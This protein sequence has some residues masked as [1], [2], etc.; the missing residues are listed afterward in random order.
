M[1]SEKPPAK[2]RRPL[3]A[4]NIFFKFERARLLALAERGESLESHPPTVVPVSDIRELLRDNPY[5]VDHKKRRH[6]RSHGMVSFSALFQTVLGNWKELTAEMRAPFDEI[7]SE[8]KAAYDQE[9]VEYK[10]WKRRE[11]WRKTKA[12]NRSRKKQEKEQERQKNSKQ[13]EISCTASH[14]TTESTTESDGAKTEGKD[15]KE[16]KSNVAR[17][18]IF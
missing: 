16:K 6:R 10:E 2:P 7:A 1:S 15:A 13:P 9:A 14:P 11:Q 5:H 18:R 3:S 8:Y 17:G 4:Y 12:R